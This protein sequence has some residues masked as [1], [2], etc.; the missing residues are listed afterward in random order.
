MR[1]YSSMTRSAAGGAAAIGWLGLGVQ[2]DA[3]IGLAGS[4]GAALWTMLLYF[5]VLTNLGVAIMLS[6]VALGRRV[7]GGERTLAGGT[8]AIVLVGVIAITLLRG[9]VE[10]SG[11]ALLADVLL[12]KAML[13]LTLMWWLLFAR[14]GPLGWR[15]PLVWA[16]YPLAYFGYALIRGAVGGPYPYPFMN[17]ARIG[18]AATLTNAAII[19]AGFLAAGWLLVGI[20]RSMRRR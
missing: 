16:L 13:V 11:G 12:H 9:V 5:T 14:H 20:D 19:A 18:W 4:P 17:V 6:L 10:L 3:S 1:C 7:P 15:D 2:L 8:L